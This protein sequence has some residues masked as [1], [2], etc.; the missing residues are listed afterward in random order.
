MA[1]SLDGGCLCGAVRYA[2]LGPP[3]DA[4]YCHC[5]I[6]QRS[7]GTPVLTWLTTVDVTLAVLDDSARVEPEYHIWRGSGI[8]WFE[9]ADSPPRHLDAG[10]DAS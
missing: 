3:V 8:T 6:C 1:Q 9:T 7:S 10:P 4:G 5:R 2:A